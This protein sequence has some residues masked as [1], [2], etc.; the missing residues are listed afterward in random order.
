ME[1]EYRIAAK[2]EPSLT[3]FSD[4]M[5]PKTVYTLVGKGGEMIHVRLPR[6]PDWEVGDVVRIEEGAVREHLVE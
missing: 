5:S 2:V 3:T 1:R 4:L 6:R